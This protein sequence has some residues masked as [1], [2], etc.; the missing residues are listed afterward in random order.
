MMEL[1]SWNTDPKGLRSV[2]AM[3]S[4]NSIFVANQVLQDPY[5]EDQAFGIRRIIGNV[6]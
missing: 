2:M 5:K 3:S 6:G 1:G 4:G